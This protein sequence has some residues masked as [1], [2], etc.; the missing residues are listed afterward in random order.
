[1]RSL[2]CCLYVVV[3]HYL[4][5]VDFFVL[6]TIVPVGTDSELSYSLLNSTCSTRAGTAT[7]ASGLGGAGFSNRDSKLSANITHHPKPVKVAAINGKP[8]V[9]QRYL[10]RECKFVLLFSFIWFFHSHFSGA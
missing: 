6:L 7:G 8:R 10:S 1:M 2:F 4:P 3:P 9:V 5:N